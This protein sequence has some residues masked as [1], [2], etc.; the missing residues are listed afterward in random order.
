M[1]EIAANKVPVNIEDEMKRSLPGLRH[2]RNHRASA[3]R[4]P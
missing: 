2:E 4:R 3:A 1:T